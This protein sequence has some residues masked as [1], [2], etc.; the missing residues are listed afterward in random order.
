MVSNW[1]AEQLQ[2]INLRNRNLLVAAAA[3][4]GKTA[5]LVE[6]VIQLILRDEVNIDQML[7]VTFTK[8]AASEM[9]ERISHALIRALHQP[10]PHLPHVRRQLTRLNQ[11][12]I[13]TLHSFC[14][15]VV[16]RYYHLADVD[17]AFRV[18]DQNEA[19]LMRLEALD[20]VME[21]AYEESAPEFLGL[22]EM[23]SSARSDQGLRELLLT[24]YDFVQSQP[25]PWLWLEEKIQ[26]YAVDAAALAQ[27]PWLVSL[28]ESAAVQIKAAGDRFNEAMKICQQPDGPA[29]YVEALEEDL[30]SAR[31]LA[32]ALSSG[33]EALYQAM[34]TLTHPRLRTVRGGNQVLKDTAKRLREEGKELLRSLQKSLF[35][36]SL[37]QWCEE[38]NQL[39]PY[40]LQLNRLL[41][42]F[43]REYQSRK[44]AKGV[45][46]FNDLEHFALKIL[47][48]A[49]AAS[50]YRQRFHY[51]FVDE[52]QDSNLVQEALLNCIARADNLFMVGDVK[53]SI[54]RFRLADPGLFMQKY[55]LYE[56]GEKEGCSRIDLK[57]NFRSQ[58]AII[59][60]VN[61]VFARIMNRHVGE[62]DYDEKAFLNHGLA[63]PEV[64]R[65]AVS[66]TI[67]DKQ[68]AGLDLAAVDESSDAVR[69]AGVVAGIIQDL[70]GKPY[71]DQAIKG[72]R[73]LKY[74]DIVV[75]LRATHNWSLEFM[76]VFA[77]KG[78][79]AYADVNMGYLGA[80]EVEVT[81]NL[82]KLID[83]HYQDIPLLSVLRSPLFALS[84]AELVAIRLEKPQ[85]AF[86][87]AFE[88]Y[89]AN[90]SDPLG[91][92]VREIRQQLSR[93]R[94]EARYLPLDQLIWQLYA[95]T[96][97]YHYV[98]ALPGGPQRQANLRILAERARQFENTSLR[99][100]YSFIRFI[101]ALRSSRRDLEMARVLGENDNVVRVMSVHKSKGL[102]FPV[103]IVA[104]LGRPFNLADSK[105]PMV[106]HKELG[107][108]SRYV[109]LTT[110]R[111][112]ESIA[113][114]AIKERLRLESLAEEMRILYV[115][116]T[117][118]QARLFMVGTVNNLDKKAAVW[119]RPQGSYELSQAKGI[120][121]WL[122]PLWI[123]H[124]DGQALREYL[125]EPPA[126]L[127]GDE[128]VPF[129]ITVLKSS[130]LLLSEQESQARQEEALARIAAS[131]DAGDAHLEDHIRER[132][133]WRYPYA[134]AVVL[135]SKL[136]V[137]Q[138][139]KGGLTGQETAASIIP[140]LNKRPIFMSRAAEAGISD[141][142]AAQRGSILHYVMQQLDL[143][144]V[145]LT[146]LQSQ[147]E[148]MVKAEMLTELEAA[149]I[150]IDK[151][152]RFFLS[153][154]GRRILAARRVFR[155]AGFN[156][157]VKAG[158]LLENAPEPEEKML[159]QGVIDLYF[160]EDDG[161]VVVD[162]KTD[163]ITAH[164]KQ[165]LI[166][167][168]RP[169]V[170]AYCQ[171]LAAIS[172]Q[173]V[174]EGFI[175]FLNSAE[176]VRVV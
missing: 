62:I 113:A 156:Q 8:A 122:G 133:S 34:Q 120:M 86:Y 134:G 2:A 58:P 84:S 152:E 111:R 75:L 60:A 124:P 98:A 73:P 48:D 36:K 101:E 174:K 159:L 52:Y 28:M 130:E 138:L 166:E 56:N 19:D 44:K 164:N 93:W 114:V 7:V 103:V 4:S 54:Y 148:A 119:A 80:V 158:Q 1:T 123:Q 55:R 17:P 46:D 35:N 142:T 30:Y 42:Q 71:Y 51:I 43:S 74:S 170:A 127:P 27:S 16:R 171:A 112:S 110:R 47:Q 20:T 45:L 23:F 176:A 162:Y 105:A 141:L 15:E 6:R 135:P 165:H 76:E 167:Q 57:M 89:C 168:Y 106:L 173:V 40:L 9:R 155:E 29:P 102:E 68:P 26:A 41:Q 137:T 88:E 87:E 128:E 129:N 38:L 161:L 153:P 139:T 5:V 78:I 53:Q 160:E 140:S 10:G 11:A 94:K 31:V 169:Q 65:E 115:A 85:G 13:S 59:A 154:L 91:E 117:R 69:E 3:G 100:L 50:E 22:I 63:V 107:I 144:N 49:Q 175:Y 18:A 118:A 82:L 147:V 12:P 92:R 132:L 25:E 125:E 32:E 72:Y 150:D 108:G 126:S 21:A 95:E 33:P 151:I 121:D 136:T 79:P 14:S 146:G 83:N 99:G 81:L 66:V 131:R 39:H 157:L 67:I 163:H 143:R 70:Q 90:C 172:G 149:S 145:G 61:Y 37:A 97:Y 116:M 77:E 109:N 24:I 96:G 104:G 64:A